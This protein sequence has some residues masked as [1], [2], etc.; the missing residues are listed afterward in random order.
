MNE[1]LL[2]DIGI[3]IIT[4][5]LTALPIS[6]LRLPLIIAFILAGILIGPNFGL[7]LVKEHQNISQISE[8]GLVLLLFILGLEINLKKLIQA[9]KSVFFTSMGQIIICLLVTIIGLTIFNPLMPKNELIYLAI[10]S[11]LSSTL[12]VVKIL[13][14]QM[15]LE[16]LTSRITLG[17]LVVQ[18][19]FVII[20]LAIQPNLN[21]LDFFSICISFAKILILVTVSYIF[22]RWILPRLFRLIS[23][24]PEILI[25]SSMSWC[26]G[27]CGLAHYLNLSLEMG[28]L[29]AGISIAS[30]PYHLDVVS[31]ISSLRD[32][33]ITLFFVSLGLQIPLPNANVIQMT[34]IFTFVI[35]MT[36]FISIFPI[37]YSIGYPSRI[38][39]LTTTNLSQLSEFSIVV[40][41]LG[42]S[43]GHISQDILSTMIL[44]TILT[45]ILSSL[46]IPNSNEI[47]YY[48][49]KLLNFFGFKDKFINTP[50]PD[51]DL[52]QKIHK[53][54]IFLGFYRDASSLLFEL[55]HRNDNLDFKKKI[56]VIDFNPD[57]HHELTKLGIT[58]NYG[59]ISHSDTL[60]SLKLDKAKLIICT[61]TDKTLKGTTNTQLLRQ[62]KKYAPQS[63]L[64]LTAEN[65]KTAIEL[66][67]LGANYVY[68]P[69][70][71]GG[72]YLSDVI[73][74]LQTFGKDSLKDQA[75]STLRKRK[76][77]LP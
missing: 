10:A 27:L 8:I 58:C 74:K 44:T 23:R 28:A 77:V 76:E 19:I 20:F 16:S 57:T 65:H 41:T 60:A 25:L 2:A 22:G 70:Q 47:Y 42:I 14:D 38:C 31:K 46:V 62:L 68:I 39:F 71:I 4:A 50:N 52:N 40:S 7:N 12:I 35:Y 56:R 1:S 45:A 49:Y 53:E 72:Y 33:F 75:L 69:R 24:Q 21:N 51:L 17:V 36:R 5:A 13:S 67:E 3:S 73:E 11:G 37:L 15:D 18:D 54:V 30:Y 26:F 43:L 29:A 6:L 32:F 48:F 55:I 9:G 64:I 59:D 34:L 63:C 66:Y 61:L